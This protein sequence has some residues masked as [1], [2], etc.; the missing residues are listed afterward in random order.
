M[1]RGIRRD[2]A[3]AMLVRGFLRLDLPY[4]PP[5][6]ARQ[7]DQVLATTEEGSL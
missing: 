5:V 2:D 4:L 7:I 1:T 3:V 6:L